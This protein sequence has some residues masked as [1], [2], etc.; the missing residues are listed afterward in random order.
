MFF[1]GH[2]DGD[3]LA[4]TRSLWDLDGWAAEARRLRGALDDATELRDG[5]LVSAEV[6][7]HL[8]ID[9]VLP[10]ELAPD[11]WPAAE[12]R[13]QFAKFM[14]DYEARLREYSQPG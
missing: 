14:T 4:L 5:F 9:P 10:P 13:G 8:L 3:R 7:R 2:P 12:L 1:S 11:D 6:Y